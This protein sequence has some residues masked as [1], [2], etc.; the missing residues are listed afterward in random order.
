MKFY[1]ILC[2]KYSYFDT[3]LMTVFILYFVTDAKSSV[4][5]DTYIKTI[6]EHTDSSLYD[7]LCLCD[8]SKLPTNI[9]KWYITLQHIWGK[10]VCEILFYI[11]MWSPWQHIVNRIEWLEFHDHLLTK[12]KHFLTKQITNAILLKWCSKGHLKIQNIFNKIIKV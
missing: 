11:F 2:H 12:N 7:C 9:C 10:L 4:E 6:L 8:S 5:E 1:I 3:Q